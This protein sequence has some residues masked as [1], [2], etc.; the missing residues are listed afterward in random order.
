MVR[1]IGIDP[2][3]SKESTIFDGNKFYQKGPEDIEKFLTS[4]LE[5]KPPSLICW[6]APLSAHIAFDNE[7]ISSFYQRKIEYFFNRKSGRKLPDGISVRGYAGCPHWAITK[8]MVGLPVIS[9]WEPSNL[10]FELIVEEDNNSGNTLNGHHIVEVHPAVAIWCYC[11]R[12]SRRKKWNYKKDKRTLKE[13]LDILKKNEVIHEKIIH[14]IIS[15]D[16][17]QDDR[18]DAYIAWK[19]GEEWISNKNK[20]R[21]LGNHKTGSF[22]LPYEKR[23]FDKFEKFE[24]N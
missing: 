13:I 11:Q 24:V 4:L 3:P 17:L 9:K 18:L 19:L 22:L 20:V 16:K 23:L 12:Y 6:D 21:I 15:E 2:A 5:K 8:Y 7:N 14:E 1:V 10:P